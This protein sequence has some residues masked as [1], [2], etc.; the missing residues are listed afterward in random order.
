MSR[1]NHLVN[2]ESAQSSPGTPSSHKGSRCQLEHLPRWQIRL[3]AL[4]AVPAGSSAPGRQGQHT[5][6]RE[7][8]SAELIG[9]EVPDTGPG[10]REGDG[11]VRCSPNGKVNA[12]RDTQ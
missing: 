8:F 11:G 5:G 6:R 2:K 7:P 3:T 9:A 1:E 10:P 12:Q 4:K